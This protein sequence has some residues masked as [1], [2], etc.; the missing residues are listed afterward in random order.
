MINLANSISNWC[1]LI[2]QV[3]ILEELL[4]MEEMGLTEDEIIGALITMT[5]NISYY[6][7]PLSNIN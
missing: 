4:E 3:G 6:N 1:E 2:I 5:E 7:R